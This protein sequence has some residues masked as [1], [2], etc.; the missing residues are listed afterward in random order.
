MRRESPSEKE[1][2]G[3]KKKE[4]NGEKVQEGVLERL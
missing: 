2:E 1:G 3:E 4:T